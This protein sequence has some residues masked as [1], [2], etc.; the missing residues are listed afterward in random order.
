M[1]ALQC[2]SRERSPLSG[3]ANQLGIG[4]RS[5]A[6]SFAW[7]MIN[8]DDSDDLDHGYDDDNED[9]HD[10]Q[11]DAVSMMTTT[12]MMIMICRRNLRAYGYVLIIMALFLTKE[13]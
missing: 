9:D 7:L 6:P 4:I 10:D 12:M 1:C 11:Y 13:N 2:H 8:E 5:S 3:D